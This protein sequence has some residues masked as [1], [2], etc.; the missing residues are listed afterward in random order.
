M[1]HRQLGHPDR[2][3]QV[4]YLLISAV[5]ALTASRIRTELLAAGMSC[6]QTELGL[7]VA[8]HDLDWRAIL[9][10]ISLILSPAERRDT[11]IARLELS[12]DRDAVHRAIFRAK[13]LETLLS[14]FREGWFEVMLAQKNIA[15]HFQPLVQYPPGRI[16]GYECLMR[17]SLVDGRPIPPTR[18]F[19]TARKLDRV[20]VLD[21]HCRSA[22]LHRAGQIADSNLV[23]F[24][25]FLPSSIAD[26]RK[27]LEE[28]LADIRQAGLRPEQV[29]FE[30]VETDKVQDRR[31]LVDVLR[32]FRK[33]GCRIA[34]D[35]VGAG[36]SSLLSF[37]TLRPD[38]IKLDGE[39]VRRASTSALEAKLVADLAETAR[40]NG[41][42][43]VA[44]GIETEQ[45]MR[46]VLNCGI[47]ITQGFFHA[48]PQAEPMRE[49]QV[50]ELI[51]RLKRV[52][53]V[54]RT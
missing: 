19:E 11:H 26:A 36:Y 22:A 8:C 46:L 1:E 20:N 13:G 42:I 16:H 32:Y 41:I 45:D 9:E 3:D 37:A 29:A 33:A 44:E 50:E 5:N 2:A 17:G 27:G 47:R 49:Q 40:Q 34:L 6:V 48:R 12:D 24:V 18:I 35:D 25:N 38:Y 54:P 51:A 43:T 39:L 23:F 10:S 31:H 30:V 4:D 52:S 7:E 14:E 21:R 15:I 28:V 53:H